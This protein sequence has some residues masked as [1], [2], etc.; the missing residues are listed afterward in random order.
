MSWFPRI[1]YRASLD[2]VPSIVIS[3]M[4][5][6]RMVRKGCLSYL[7]FVRDVGA[8]TPTIDSVLVVR[9][10]PYVFPADL[11]G[12]LP[13]RDIDFGL[14]LAPG[15]QPISIPLCGMARVELKEWKDHRQELL[16]KGFIRPSVSLW[17]LMSCF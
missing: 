14:D 17:K 12:M 15:T 8:D 11:P 9:D 1:E 4:K 13:D 5:A 16:D 10:F 3:Y 7:A 6:Q 2:Y